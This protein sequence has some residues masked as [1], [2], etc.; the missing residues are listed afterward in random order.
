MAIIGK[1]E[2]V[3]LAPRPVPAA[4]LGEAA[5]I[6]LSHP[7]GR[8]LA[9]Q[10]AALAVLRAG[11]G[12]PGRA[13]AAIVAGVALWWPFQEW[14]A[15]R[16]VLHAAP[17]QVAG[18]RLDPAV[19]RY[20]RRHHADPWNLDLTMLPAWF[21][22]PAV[23]AHAA[24]WTLACRDRRTALTGMLA[25][26]MAA[27][28]YEWTHYLTHT[29]YRPRRS[30]F[31]RLQRRHRL[32]HFKHEQRWFGFTVPWVDDLL[33]TAPDPAGVVTSPTVRTLGVGESATA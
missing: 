13:D 27:L 7:S 31:R 16:F 9:G 32:H 3:A 8:I 14:L 33:R 10:V 18:R 23:P 28:A 22:L 20:H 5:V 15:H 2:P 24:A 19:A 30:W 17:R 12:R 4:D 11:A 6:F 21:V 29:G 25:F 1:D 26:G